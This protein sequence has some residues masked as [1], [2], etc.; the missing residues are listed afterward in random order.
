MASKDCQSGGI[1]FGNWK[2]FPVDVLNY[3]L[4]HRHAATDN[5]R[6]RDAGT[7][8]EVKWH[9][10]GRYYSYNTMEHA[11]WYAADVELK[12]EASEREMGLMEAIGLLRETLDGF[13]SDVRSALRGVVA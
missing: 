8:G 3:E 6:S 5:A 13:A 11:L 4:C 2:L 12:A 9:R 1:T 7:V 10:L